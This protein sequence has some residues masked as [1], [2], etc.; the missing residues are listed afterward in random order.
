MQRSLLNYTGPISCWS[1]PQAVGSSLCLCTVGSALQHGA[2][3]SFHAIWP[4]DTYSRFAWFTAGSVHR[5][6]Q[7]IDPELQ[8]VP[9]R[10]LSICLRMSDWGQPF[11]ALAQP[12]FTWPHEN[13]SRDHYHSCFGNRGWAHKSWLL[14]NRFSRFRID[15]IGL[16]RLFWD[17]FL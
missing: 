2:R 8:S 6:S 9:L 13:V 10:C 7:E 17:G 12:L 1:S 3:A 16:L 14:N 5:R 4:T 15:L 11:T